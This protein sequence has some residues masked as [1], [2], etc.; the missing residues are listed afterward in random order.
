MIGGAA[1]ERCCA[2]DQVADLEA[3]AVGEEPLAGFLICGAQ[4]GVAQFAG[5]DRTCPFHAGGSLIEPVGSAGTVAGYS[6]LGSCWRRSAISTSN[7]YL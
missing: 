3:D 2:F 5:L 7:G 6:R 4:Y 1:D